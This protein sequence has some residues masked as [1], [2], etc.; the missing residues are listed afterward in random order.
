LVIEIQLIQVLL[1][2]IVKNKKLLDIGA[3]YFLDFFNRYSRDLNAP[4]KKELLKFFVEL[5]QNMN[6]K[7][8]GI[9]YSNHS[10][11]CFRRWS[12]SALSHALELDLETA[13]SLARMFSSLASILTDEIIDDFNLGLPLCGIVF[14]IFKYPKLRYDDFVILIPDYVVLSRK[15][16]ISGTNLATLSA[17]MK[18]MLRLEIALSIAT[19][20]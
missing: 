11:F 20:L 19:S 15:L 13:H 12:I 4:L 17:A 14:S 9:F 18:N 3:Q 16:S 6:L 7:V 2:A 10:L 1:Q 8:E 5:F